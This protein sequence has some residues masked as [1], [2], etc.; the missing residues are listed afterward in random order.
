MK[1]SLTLIVPALNEERYLADTVNEAVEAL[2]GLIDDYEIY[3]F[4]DG[5]TDRTGEIADALAAENA[6]IEAIHH[7]RPRG[8]GYNYK[9]GVR[10]AAKEYVLMIPGD[11]EVHQDSVRNVCAQVGTADIVT[12]YHLNP[13]IRPRARQVISKVFAGLIRAASGLNVRYFNGLVVHRTDLVRRAL[14]EISDG[15]A[16]QAEILVR[17]IQLGLKYREVGLLIHPRPKT[18]AFRLSNLINTALNTF[19]LVCR[20]RFTENSFTLPETIPAPEPVPT[21]KA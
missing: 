3:I 10:R 19:R 7:D 12:T 11:N 14:A 1:P 16:Y 15:F 8:L 13:E 5:S 17:L 18:S 6:R 20:L 21:W 4:N 9:A 2:E